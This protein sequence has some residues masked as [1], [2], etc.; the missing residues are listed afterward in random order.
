MDVVAAIEL[1]VD[2]HIAE[3]TLN[4]GE[5]RFNP[6]FLS[7]FL[8]KLDEI[9]QETDCK[10]LIVTSAHEKIFCNG[11]DLDWLM[12]VVAAGDLEAGKRF[13]Y[14]LNDLLR[15]L[16]TYPLI[17]IAAIN[18]HAFAGGAIMACAFDFRFMR[19]DRGYFCFPEVDLG[20]PFLPGMNAI[21]QSAIP[22]H[23]LAEMQLT[24]KR[25]TAQELEANH[26][27]T[28][29]CSL[30]ELMPAARAFAQP[31]EKGREIVRELKAR[32]TKDIV[33]AIDVL[34]RPYIDSGKFQYPD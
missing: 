11:I 25:V 27:I 5:N 23:L 13:F 24:G 30:E 20:I 33:H 9:E 12:P 22:A 18:G 6:E 8:G 32:A 10:T 4:D 31:L 21:V 17:T 16:A 14:Q 1:R 19:Q 3:V 29:A 26:V 34:D 2:G 28:Q 7:A 15:R